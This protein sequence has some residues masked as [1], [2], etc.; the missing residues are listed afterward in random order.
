MFLVQIFLFG[1][2]PSFDLGLGIGLQVKSWK[3]K[4]TI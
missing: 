1:L 4:M 2:I 3:R